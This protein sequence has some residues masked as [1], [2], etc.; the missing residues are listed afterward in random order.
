MTFRQLIAEAR[1]YLDD[2][3]EPYLW[4]DDELFSYATTALEVFATET[5]AIE[6]EV[7]IYYPANASFVE[8]PDNVASIKHIFDYSGDYRVYGNKLWLEELPEIGILL[9]CL[10][11]VT[12]VESEDLD[13]ELPLRA[14]YQ[15][16]LIPGI[17]S[18][19][20]AKQDVETYNAERMLR[21]QQTFMMN[22]E[23]VKRDLVRTEQVPERVMIHRG[24]L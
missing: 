13:A 24:L 20:Y 21:S 12:S 15:R 16:Y 5:E 10:A 7:F 22:I 11:A 17:C 3:R 19:A 6:Q 23:R 8:L 18:I 2:T 1:L 9:R 14:R 4:S